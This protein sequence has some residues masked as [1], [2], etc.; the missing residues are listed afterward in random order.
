MSMKRR[1]EGL[2]AFCA[3]FGHACRGIVF[4]FRSQRNFRIHLLAAT[5][6]LVAAFA[7][8]LSR[9]EIIL[10]LLTSILVITAELLNTAIE[11]VLNLLEARHHP[12]VK[13]AKD[14]AAGGVLLTVG[15][16]ILVGLMIFGPPLLVRLRSCCR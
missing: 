13:T 9:T 1:F 4:A 16:S 3:S 15:A 6:V 5:L 7:F 14:V 11:Y 2:F 8:K 12:V 10:L